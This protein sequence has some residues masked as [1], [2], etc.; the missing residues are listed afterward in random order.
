M[1]GITGRTVAALTITLATLA[2]DAAPSAPGAH[3]G[4]RP[5]ALAAS[6]AAAT[7]VIPVRQG[8]T[9]PYTFGLYLPCA[10]GGQGDWVD[11]DG[12]LTFQGTYLQTVNDRAHHQLIQTFTGTATSEVTGE[13]YDVRSREVDQGSQTYGDDGILDSGQDFQRLQ[14]RL[15]NGTTGAVVDVVLSVHFVQNATGEWVLGGWEGTA[16]CR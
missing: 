6:G 7:S 4:A 15:T 12:Q 2:C 14:V 10:N 3:S 13:T 11:I 1:L 16:R 8:A 9:V 5:S